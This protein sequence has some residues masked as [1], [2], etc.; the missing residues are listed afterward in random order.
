MR[1]ANPGGDLS[2]VF[3]RALDLLVAD[4]EKRKQGRTKRPQGKDG[5]E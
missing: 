4:L 5:V 3:E 1:H 2:V